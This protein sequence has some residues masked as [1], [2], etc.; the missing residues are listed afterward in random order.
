MEYT[1]RFR[2]LA[3]ELYRLNAM[4][5]GGEIAAYNYSRQGAEVSFR[6]FLS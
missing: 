1:V 2:D 4:L 6:V 5:R 3:Y